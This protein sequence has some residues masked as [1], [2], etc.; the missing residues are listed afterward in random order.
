[1]FKLATFLNMKKLAKLYFA[2][3][4]FSVINLLIKFILLFIYKNKLES[5]DIDGKVV[6]IVSYAFFITYFGIGIYQKI[7]LWYRNKYKLNDLKY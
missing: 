2:Y 3:V 1:M 4:I 7:I 6:S 5:D